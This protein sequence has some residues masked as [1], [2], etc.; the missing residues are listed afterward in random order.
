MRARD[1]FSLTEVMVAVV[2]LAISLL[3]IYAVFIKTYQVSGRTEA[4]EIANAL[5]QETM[6]N[7]VNKPFSNLALWAAAGT[8]P[9]PPDTALG[10]SVIKVT[11]GTQ[12]DYVDYQSTT[13]KL[14][15]IFTVTTTITWHD[16]DDD[17]VFG[18]SP[19]DPDP[20]DYKRVHMVVSWPGGSGI[21]LDRFVSLYY[22]PYGNSTA[23]ANAAVFTASD[24]ANLGSTTINS[25]T[26][27]NKTAKAEAKGFST[28]N[29]NDESEVKAMVFVD[30]NAGSASPSEDNIDKVVTYSEAAP[31]HLKSGYSNTAK[32][33]AS[34]IENIIDDSISW[35]SVEFLSNDGWPVSSSEWPSPPVWSSSWKQPSSIAK[36]ELTGGMYWDYSDPKDIKLFE[37]GEAR[38]GSKSVIVA[39]TSN[40]KIVTRSWSKI[41][42]IKLI[43]GGLEDG[44]INPVISIDSVEARVE[45]EANGTAGGAKVNKQYWKITG[46]KVGS[47]DPVTIEAPD[48]PTISVISPIQSITVAAENTSSASADGTSAG[49]EVLALKILI[50]ASSFTYN[51]ETVSVPA[52]TITLGTAD[53]SV[54]YTNR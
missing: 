52:A 50:S 3:T 34:A 47:A 51:S 30:D 48:I 36:S 22:R 32:V 44:T 15:I 54:S 5:A 4:R 1:G 37:T 28:N 13:S 23:S 38:S 10:E 53:A 17:G 19:S 16:D 18:G 20:N 49:A 42:N 12:S 40:D 6:E 39:G 25:Y 7:V 27:G 8:N 24:Y 26:G 35:H 45:I 33:Q 41:S 14:G 29:F 31:I 11:S 2:I 9:M 43:E 46:L 21:T